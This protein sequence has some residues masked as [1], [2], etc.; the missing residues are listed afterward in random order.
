MR[1][2]EVRNVHEA[3]PEGMN[4]LF[5]EGI[6]ESSRGGEVLVFPTPVCTV[7]THPWERVLFWSDRDAN[8]FFH[9]MESLWM[10]S[11]SRDVEWIARFNENMRSFSDDGKVFHGAYGYRWK[12]HFYCDDE[13]HHPVDQLDVVLNLLTIDRSSRRAVI[14]MWDCTHDLM[15]DGGSH[16]DLPCNTQI[17]LA[18]RGHHLDMTVLCRSNDIIWGAYGANAVHFSI[19]QEY[20]AQILGLISGKLYQFSNNYHAYLD[21]FKKNH[22]LIGQAKDP[23][24]AD[25]W[26]PYVSDEVV[27][28]PLV[29]RPASFMKELKIFMDET[30]MG[31]NYPDVFLDV[32]P[33]NI[34]LRYAAAVRRSYLLWKEKKEVDEAL[35]V[36]K[37]YTPDDWDFG[38]ACV[39]W[40]ERRKERSGSLA[41]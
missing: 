9:L 34:F 4:L 20:L 5:S 22:H 30:F 36:L 32:E 39:Q 21:V 23:Y 11:G 8:P 6:K 40:L 25:S 16:K 33:E 17:Y 2:I 18:V 14:Q 15:V 38:V 31:E 1:V 28:A 3:L 19:L 24:K 27:A 37:N 35:E 13:P 12:R 7:Y 29:T 41:R 26:N 10:L